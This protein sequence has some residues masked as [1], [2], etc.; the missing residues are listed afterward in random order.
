MRPGLSLR[1]SVGGKRT[2]DTSS[3]TD[4]GIL[5]GLSA[6]ERPHVRIALARAAYKRARLQMVAG[7]R[8]LTADEELQCQPPE[9]VAP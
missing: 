8:S 2:Q 7:T 9:S 4:L 1:E 3:V 5:V 6:A